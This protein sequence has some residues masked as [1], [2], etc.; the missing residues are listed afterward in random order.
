MSIG[1]NTTLI[2]DNL[3][4]FANVQQTYLVLN[5]LTYLRVDTLI[6]GSWTFLNL[7]YYNN[8]SFTLDVGVL[9]APSQAGV[10]IIGGPQS[11]SENGTYTVIINK[12]SEY[13]SVNVA[14]NGNLTFSNDEAVEASTFATALTSSGYYGLATYLKLFYLF[15][16]LFI[17][18]YINH[19]AFFVF[20]ISHF[21]F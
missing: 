20:R 11:A 8:V 18:F 15:I 5:N 3:G 19:I 17:W 2:I 14:D 7:D 21:A 10:L 6:L 16:Y 9:T 4:W 12:A 1:G 13:V